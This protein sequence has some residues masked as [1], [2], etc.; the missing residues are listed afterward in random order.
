MIARS[1]EASGI[2]GWLLAKK[3]YYKNSAGRMIDLSA[4]PIRIRQK[5]SG[6]ST[7]EWEVDET[8][9]AMGSR[10][11]GFSKRAY[12]AE[13][14]IDFS[15]SRS[16]RAEALQAF[17]EI[18][19]YDVRRKMD[20]ADAIG[21]I[22]VDNQYIEC[23][24]I[25][26]EPQYYEDRFR[27]LGK[28]CS[29]YV[30]YPFWIED[31]TTHFLPAESGDAYPYLDYT[32]DYNYDYSRRLSGTDVINNAHF[33]SSGFQIVIY[34]PCVDPY[35]TIGGITYK[36]NTTVLEG[37]HLTI[38]SVDKT[39]QRTQVRGTVINEFN[40]REKDGVSIFTPIGPGRQ[41]V[42][43]PGTFG[44]DVILRQERSELKWQ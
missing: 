6:F 13:M 30:P 42:V 19:E 36:V 44:F 14:V 24:I 39:V 28:K 37:E 33:V 15:G 41:S 23:Y 1:A 12:N 38:N 17:Y 35:V 3:I 8:E 34:G 26:S 16:Q 11:N 25:T 32:Y 10:V 22:Y 2:W 27:T 9:L 31:V 29:L 43:W 21:R 4:Y 5:S 7:Y 40:N 20:G 18:T